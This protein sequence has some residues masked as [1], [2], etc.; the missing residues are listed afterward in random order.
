[1]TYHF[2]TLIYQ[3]KHNLI[4]LKVIYPELK[5]DLIVANQ[6]II[7]LKFDQVLLNYLHFVE[8]CY[9]LNEVLIEKL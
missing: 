7:Q 9:P 2:L 4:A 6:R 5:V 3:I 8:F 1:M